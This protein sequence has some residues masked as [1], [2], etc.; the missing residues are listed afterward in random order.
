MTVLWNDFSSRYPNCMVGRCKFY[1]WFQG[2]AMLLLGAIQLGTTGFVVHALIPKQRVCLHLCNSTGEGHVPCS[3]SKTPNA[4][5]L[6]KSSTIYSQSFSTLPYHFA[7]YPVVRSLH[8]CSLSSSSQNIC[9]Q[10]HLI[11]HH[12]EHSP[13]VWRMSSTSSQNTPS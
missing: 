12:E 5:P 10:I 13:C 1:G 9:S 4:M 3:V 6:T 8:H 2:L 11:L 7:F